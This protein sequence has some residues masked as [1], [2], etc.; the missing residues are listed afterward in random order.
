VIYWTDFEVNPVLKATTILATA[1]AESLT[2]SRNEG[3]SEVRI[4][5]DTKRDNQETRRTMTPEAIQEQTGSFVQWRAEIQ[6]ARMARLDAAKKLLAS[7]SPA[8]DVAE[9]Q[10]TMSDSSFVIE[11]SENPQQRQ[12]SRLESPDESTRGGA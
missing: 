12:G 4:M 1:G 5:D 9:K 10:S 3:G 6:Q 8:Q 7:I 11:G 2:E